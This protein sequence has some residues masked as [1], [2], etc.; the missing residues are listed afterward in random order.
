[1]SNAARKRGPPKTGTQPASVSRSPPPCHTAIRPDTHNLVTRR[2]PVLPFIITRVRATH[3]RRLAPTA[4]HIRRLHPHPDG[5]L[6]NG[7]AQLT[8]GKGAA[9]GSN[10]CRHTCQ[11]KRNR[12]RNCIQLEA[13][14]GSSS[15]CPYPPTLGNSPPSC[16]SIFRIT[17]AK[18]RLLTSLSSTSSDSFS[19]SVM[20]SSTVSSTRL[21]NRPCIT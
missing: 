14:H 18:A 12:N 3:P 11:Y 4:L 17:N 7:L 19:W 6:N 5:L 10:Q 2:M 15:S 20:A 21:G 16:V 8:T 1:R 9:L 13:V